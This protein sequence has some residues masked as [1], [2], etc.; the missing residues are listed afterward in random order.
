MLRGIAADPLLLLMAMAGLVLLIACANIANLTLARASGRQRETGVR[1]ALGASRARLIR[2]SLSESLLVAVLGGIAGVL[3]ASWGVGGLLTI[4]RPIGSFTVAPQT[5]W[6]VAGFSAGVSILTAILF[7]LAPA[8]RAA[9]VDVNRTLG[10]GTRGSIATRSVMRTGRFLVVAQIALS[11]LLIS[12]AAL[13]VRT[14]H[15]LIVQP[16][17]FDRG[18]MLSVQIDPAAHKGAAANAFFLD[19]LGKL[20]HIPGVRG[21]TLSDSGLFTGSDSGDALAAEGSPIHNAEELRARWTEIGPRYFSTLGIPLLAG[22]EPD[23]ADA[24]RGTPVC[25]IN[26][27]FAERFYPGM[28]P[29]G[30]H[31]TDEYPTTRETYEIVGIAA[32]AREHNPDERPQPRFSAT[33][34][35]PIG[36]VQVVTFLIRGFGDSAAL[37][38]AVR[39]TIASVDPTVRIMT[40]GTLQE[41]LERRVF[42]RR[43]LAELSAFFGALALLMAAIGLYG[44]MAYSITRRTSEI[45]LRMALGASRES[46]LRMVLREALL[47]VAW[48]VALGLPCA[49]AAARLLGNLLFGVSPADPVTFSAVAAVILASAVAAAFF[50][51]WRAMRVDPLTALRYD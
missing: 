33:L 5:D 3:L 50:P 10:S 42:S 36:T 35:H 34:F 45:G 17:G 14:L 28:N 43:I 7:G 37:A 6:R 27:T 2:E 25:V 13:F 29:I 1:L 32:D 21:V 24:L 8:L 31:I 20:E 41:R 38:P 49:Y 30:R 39:E 4:F 23:A 22:R 16:V 47:L 15:N 19:V 40:L 48:G 9:R 44:V 11:L 26:R 12:S 51:A 18:N 46:I